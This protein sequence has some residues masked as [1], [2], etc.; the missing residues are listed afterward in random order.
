MSS[1]LV[2]FYILS[3]CMSLFMLMLTHGPLVVCDLA[4]AGN[5]DFVADIIKD[6]T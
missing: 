2:A 4:S 1:D 5:A 3:N 6:Y